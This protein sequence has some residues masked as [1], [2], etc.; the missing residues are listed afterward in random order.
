MSAYDN[1]FHDEM[2]KCKNKIKSLI[3]AKQ[4]IDLHELLK[5]KL[6]E[7]G[8]ICYQCVHIDESVTCLIVIY[9][10]SIDSV[11]IEKLNTF[12][13]IDSSLGTWG[14][15]PYYTAICPEGNKYNFLPVDPFNPQDFSQTIN[16]INNTKTQH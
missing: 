9:C 13:W 7:S 1:T 14:N 3:A 4:K 11:L 10:R 15:K 16:L 5:N 8:I 2:N 12:R 6:R